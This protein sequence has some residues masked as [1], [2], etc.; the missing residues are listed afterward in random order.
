[1]NFNP[2]VATGRASCKK[3]NE[4]IPKGQPCLELV[5]HGEEAVVTIWNSKK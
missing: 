2:Q 5:L 1:M 3:G 4:V